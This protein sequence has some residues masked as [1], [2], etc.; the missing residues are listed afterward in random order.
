MAPLTIVKLHRLNLFMRLATGNNS[1]AKASA[2]AANDSQKG[3]F[4]AVTADFDWAKQIDA[5]CK[6]PCLC[7]VQSLAEWIPLSKSRIRWWKVKI[8]ELC[9]IE[10]ANRVQEVATEGATCAIGEVFEC[11]ICQNAQP[12]LQQLRLHQF[13]EH[14]IKREARRFIGPLV[15]CPACFRIYPTRNI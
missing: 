15:N 13:R 4:A 6:A 3:W 12:T 9:R 11:D 7:T 2:F 1:V 5:T 8:R 14:G 10:E